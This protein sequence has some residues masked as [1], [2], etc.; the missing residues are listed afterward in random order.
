[1]FAPSRP[2]PGKFLLVGLF[3]ALSLTGCG[4]PEE[5][6]PEKE[7][8]VVIIDENNTQPPPNPEDWVD[9]PEALAGSCV[10]S[11]SAW[12]AGTQAFENQTARAGFE[13][14]GAVGTRLSVVDFDQDGYPDVVARRPAFHEDDWSGGGKRAFW[15]LRNKGDGSF[16]DVT[17]ASGIVARRDGVTG[18]GRPAETIVWG[19]FNRDGFPDAVTSYGH[20]TSSPES[21]EVMFNNGDGTFSFGPGTSKFFRPNEVRNTAGLALVDLNR[22]GILDMFEGN[23]RATQD[24]LYIGRGVG[25]FS[26]RTEEAGLITSEWNN[27]QTLNA[28]QAHTNTWGVTA[29]DLNNDG[30]S[31]L[32]SASYGRAPNHLWLGE[33]SGDTVRFTN[34]S[35]ASGY[36]F[37]DAQDW[38]DNESARCHCKLNPNAQDCAGV[39]EPEVTRCETQADVLRWQHSNDREA[40]RLGGNTGTTFCADLNNDGFLDLFDLQIVHFDVGSS[41]D[42]SGVLYNKGDATFERPG[43]D[44]TGLTRD[45][46]GAVAWDDGDITG[47]AMD[48]DN[49]GRLDVYIG[50]TDY[51]GTRGHLYHQ[52]AQGT[53]DAVAPGDGIDHKSSHG[54]AVADFDQDGDQDVVVGHSRNRCSTGDHCY[55]GAH[56]RFFENVRGAQSGNW[57]QL[58]LVGGPKTNLMALGAQVTVKAAGR[59]IVQEV[60][61]GHGHYGMQHSSVLH[62]GLGEACE[63]QVTIRWPD[64]TLTTQTLTLAAGYTYR[65]EQDKVPQV[66]FG[67]LP[68]AQ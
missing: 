31:E 37:D 19:D 27:I 18:K 41:S 57:V 13:A 48:F 6:T 55:E 34:H 8:P 58:K 26:I 15:L 33:L 49:D 16:E 4:E 23:G 25:S 61:G 51:N 29:C 2:T 63:A 22:D 68:A 14:L 30:V 20:G 45:R 59:T 9:A 60:D 24:T 11:P 67:K 43:N 44:A 54:V 56:L 38:R 12:S 10:E 3:C 50:S 36:A 35:I 5:K 64:A 40:F 28:A 32:L 47:A 46:G 52:N 7:P 1:M 65:V 42:P 53:F 21:S 39:P 62:F 17:K 66:K